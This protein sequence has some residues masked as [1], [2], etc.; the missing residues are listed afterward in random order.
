MKT[1]RI[2]WIALGYVLYL[3]SLA[4]IAGTSDVQRQYADG[5]LLCLLFA[6]G[7]GGVIA[8]SLRNDDKFLSPVYL[9]LLLLSAGGLLITLY[10]MMST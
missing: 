4:L 8:S 1:S 6:A 3:A 10:V 7:I 9:Y 2:D 5:F